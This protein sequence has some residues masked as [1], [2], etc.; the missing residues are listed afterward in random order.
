MSTQR[1]IDVRTAITMLGDLPVDHVHT[2]EFEAWRP[3]FDES[4]PCRLGEA[5]HR[6][7]DISERSLH[8]PAQAAGVISQ[9]E[10]DPGE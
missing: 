9:G 7:V 5:V 2:T 8:D 1:R 10:A 3:A 6:V 4:G